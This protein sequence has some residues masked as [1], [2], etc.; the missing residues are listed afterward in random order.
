MI[1]WFKMRKYKKLI[2]SL[3]QFMVKNGYTIKPL[4]K[5]IF[6]DEQQEE[7]VFIKTGYYDPNNMEVYVF[8]NDRHIKDILRSL[9]HELIHH[10]QN[11]DGRLGA[12]SYDGET[13]YN[14]EKLQ[15]LE[16]EA[17]LRGNIA[18]RTWTETINK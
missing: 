1:I 18:F 5:V 4:P 2:V 12:G 9:A 13:I 16:E 10:K 14:D 8:T 17:Y 6:N 15:R 11:V 3:I 7:D